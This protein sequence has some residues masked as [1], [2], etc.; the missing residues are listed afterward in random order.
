MKLRL[1]INPAYLVRDEPVLMHPMD[2]IS[3][4]GGGTLV[5][6]GGGGGILGQV[7]GVRSHIRAVG[8]EGGMGRRMFVDDGQDDSTRHLFGGGGRNE[9]GIDALRDR[10]AASY[11]SILHRNSFMEAQV[12]SLSPLLPSEQSASSPRARNVRVAH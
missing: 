11:T 3:N 4:G 1:T 6:S 5:R 9:H 8:G 7:Q 10:G 2:S 12:M